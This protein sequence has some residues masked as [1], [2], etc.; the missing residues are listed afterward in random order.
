MSWKRP[1]KLVACAFSIVPGPKR[2]VLY[3]LTQLAL[4]LI[5]FLP[6][7]LILI[8]SGHSRL[9]SDDFCHLTSG[10]EYGPWEN[11]LFWRSNLNGKFSYYLL[12]GLV[13]PLDTRAP[14]VFVAI[15]IAALTFGFAW[16]IHAGRQLVARDSTPRAPMIVSA[17]ALVA[18]S[19]HELATPQSIF[20][21]ST[22]TTHT[23][24]IAILSLMLAG[25]CTAA[26]HIRSNRRLTVAAAVFAALAFVNAGMSEVFGV[27]Q[28]ALFTTL[29]PITYLIVLRDY[30][31]ICLILVSSGFVATVIALAVMPTAPGVTRRLAMFDRITTSPISSLADLVT[32]TLQHSQSFFLNPA[33]MAMTFISLFLLLRVQPPARSI[34]TRQPFQ[35]A[36]PPLILCVIAQVLNLP[37]VLIHQSDSPVLFGR[38]SLS[39]SLVIS[40]QIILLSGLAAVL[41]LRQR[42]N[43]ILR[44][45]PGCWV[46]IPLLTL[47]VALFLFGMSYFRGIHLRAAT[48]I[49]CSVVTLL[50]A[51]LWQIHVYMSA[52]GNKSNL[53]PAVTSVIAMLS[54]AALAAAFLNLFVG[55]R[56]YLYSL[57]FMS[58]AAA[59]AG[60]VYGASLAYAILQ[61]DKTTPR[62]VHLSRVI[63]VGCA[64]FAAAIWFG[65]LADIATLIPQYEQ[66]SRAWDERHQRILTSRDSGVRLAE[67]PKLPDEIPDIPGVLRGHDYW[68]SSCASYEVTALIKKRY[69]A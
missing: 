8:L 54:V 68:L 16:M 11:V 37:I 64:I 5:A 28:L 33:F 55:R 60:F 48:Y 31:R 7:L 23:L 52:S 61:V 39:Y 47:G 65:M 13:A 18:I 49:A 63:Q 19:I 51:L 15:I 27:V 12:H 62:S 46:A 66:F 3:R 25:A 1:S 58:F 45:R 53:F 2:Q 59:F 69:Q 50:F 42:I 29:L 57:P 34:P 6:L 44:E 14:S 24:P 36:A 30:R 35:L 21:Y 9:T 43:F 38:F 32:V 67:P 56:L 40:V 4:L 10:L 22:A 17:A 20:H 41:L 26:P